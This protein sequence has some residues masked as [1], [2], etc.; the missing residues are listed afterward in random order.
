MPLS[1]PL[2]SAALCAALALAAATPLV[3][4]PAAPARAQA[5]ADPAAPVRAGVITLKR[6]QVPVTDTAPGRAAA[7][8]SAEIRP[9]VDGVLT[10]VLYD[11]GTTVT[12]GTPLF[13]IDSASYDA[14]LLAEKANLES[15][16]AALPAAQ[17]AADR[18][19]ALVGRG[20]TQADL[21]QAEVTLL[22]A[23][24]A[25]STAEASVA[26]AQINVD[27]TT[28]TAP[29]DGVAGIPDVSVGD[30]VTSGQSD[31][32]TTIIA[33]DPI[34]VDVSQASSR[35]LDYRRR[36]Q[37]GDIQPGERLGVTLVLENGEEYSGTG[38]VQA[39]SSSVS[40]TTGTINARLRFDNPD[41]QILPGMFLRAQLT[42]GTTSAFLVPQLAAKPQAD[43]TVQI[44]TIG[45]DGTSR[46]L[47]VTPIG[48]T[49][50]AWIVAEGIEDGT[51]LLVDNIDTMRAGRT[52]T[53]VEV[54]IADDGTLSDQPA[55]STPAP[56]PMQTPGTS[57]GN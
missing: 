30:L 47:K 19:K 8:D 41:G 44:W 40:T 17:S 7:R 9:L 5:A 24:A 54:A 15:A 13:R 1:A 29:L 39:V 45:D 43:G 21:D 46:S 28:I 3:L 53:P 10:E 52:I 27:R 48:S 25:I 34:Y 57:G 33:L 20:V 22:Q 2:R 11:P 12:K 38:T 55:A 6:Q 37:N 23:R 51:R 14:E 26:S 42:L 32:L 31:A 16:R 35:M 4:A 56:A 50:T 36:F 49:R 18:A